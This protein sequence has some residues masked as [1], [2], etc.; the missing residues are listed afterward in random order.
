[1]YQRILVPI[2]GSPLS[3]EIIPYAVGLASVHDTELVLLR[4]VDGGL[5]DDE[6]AAAARHI[7]QLAAAY[8]ARGLCVPETDGTANR[9]LEEAE[10]EP[11]TL[12]AMTS[13]GRS[14]LREMLL[15]SV[16]QYLLREMGGPVFVYHPTGA[17]ETRRASVALKR[18]VL[19]LSGSEAHGRMAEDAA[20]FAHWIGAEL[21]VVSVIEPVSAATL[22]QV[23]ESD[24]S[25]MESAFVRSTAEKLAKKHGVRVNWDALHGSPVNAIVERVSGKPDTMLAMATHRKSALEAAFLGSVTGGCLRRA[26][27]P[28][29]MR[30]P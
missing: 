13:H 26:G 12:L 16:A 2:D 27:V 23:P 17:P 28:I 15:G 3:K 25:V 6:E 22:A 18:V 4:V 8:G 7:E 21:E 10:R 30:A 5:L 1:M 9:I 24:F 29:L 20:R 11:H 19:P 14:G